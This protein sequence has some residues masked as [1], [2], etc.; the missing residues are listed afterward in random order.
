MR[1]VTSVRGMFTHS[2]GLIV[3]LLCSTNTNA[4]LD[5]TI[6]NISV[7][8]MIQLPHLN[9]LQNCCNILDQQYK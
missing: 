5:F 9:Y 4:I 8:N 2:L 7:S 6:L 1:G 3:T